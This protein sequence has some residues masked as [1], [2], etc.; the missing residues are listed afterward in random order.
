MSLN[1]EQVAEWSHSHTLGPG[2]LP[3]P[4]YFRVLVSSPIVYGII[5]ADEDLQAWHWRVVVADLKG[6]RGE[7]CRSVI[8]KPTSVSRKPRLVLARKW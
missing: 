1:S 7:N 5:V 2:T 8:N 3:C 4:V 6:E